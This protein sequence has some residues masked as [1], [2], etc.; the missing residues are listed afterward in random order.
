MPKYAKMHSIF[1][2][3]NDSREDEIL[4]NAPL[5]NF[6]FVSTKNGPSVLVAHNGKKSTNL[7]T[8]KAELN[9]DVYKRYTQK[10]VDIF[11]N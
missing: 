9:I 4:N 6:H 3:S 5:E 2:G 1:S 11:L 8:S 10:R 7:P